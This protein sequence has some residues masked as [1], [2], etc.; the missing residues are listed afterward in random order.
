MAFG[1]QAVGHQ[2]GFAA[3]AVVHLE[4]RRVN[5]QVVE[6]DG[7]QV[8]VAPG[9]ELVLDLLTDPADGRLI[10][11]R[12]G[13]RRLDVAI[14][15]PA[16]PP[17]DHQALQRVRLGD[18]AAQQPRTERLEGVADL[19][20]LQRDLASGGLDAG[21]L[22]AVAMTLPATVAAGVAVTAQELGELGLQRRLQRQ[23]DTEPSDLLQHLADL[24]VAIG[25]QRVDLA[26]DLLRGGYPLLRHGRTS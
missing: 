17:R 4:M 16:H 10:A 19:G 13:Q 23:P 20:A 25:E 3:R 9:G 21:G 22:I 11:Q 6:L 18:P 15:Q 5:E 7:G 12:L 2:H 24:A 14:R 8:T 1:G 26:P